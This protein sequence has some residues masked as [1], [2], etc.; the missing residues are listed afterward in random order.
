MTTKTKIRASRHR[1]QH[2]TAIVR[3]PLEKLHE[4]PANPAPTKDEIDEMAAW[5]SRDQDEPI[6]V[7]GD[8]EGLP[9]GH[10]QVLAGHRR[11]AAA[12]KLKWQGLECR[13]R[14]DLADDQKALT[15]MAATNQQRNAENAHRQALML[16]AMLDAGLSIRDAGAVYGLKSEAGVRNKLQLLKL[17]A[18]WIERIV[19][20]EISETAARCLVPYA[21]VPQL[22]AALNKRFT[23]PYG[24]DWRHRSTVAAAVRAV[25]SGQTRPIEKGHK[26]YYYE[27]GE[28]ARMF[29]LD[30]SLRDKLKIVRLPLGKGGRHVERATNVKLYDQLQQPLIKKKLQARPS[31]GGKAKPGK[32]S[33]QQRTSQRQKQLAERYRRWKHRMLR[34]QIAAQLEVD[35]WRTTLAMLLVIHAAGQC[36]RGAYHSAPLDQFLLSAVRH[37]SCDAARR[38]KGNIPEPEPYVS[39]AELAR[40]LITSVDPDGDPVDELAHLVHLQVA[41]L[42]W[43]QCEEATGEEPLSRG[44]PDSLPPLE[45]DLCAEIAHLVGATIAE[46]WRRGAIHGSRERPLVRE[47]FEIH[48]RAE[49]QQLGPELLG[50]VCGQLAD[51]R[52]Q[53]VSAQIDLVM[54]FHGKR[55]LPLPKCLREPSK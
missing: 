11:L 33:D 55:P 3:L 27:Q 28:H 39:D 13:I 31:R 5:L 21:D 7:R 45:D 49:L 25:I 29:R 23:N 35:D 46:G 36:P 41:F 30:D 12:R 54:G 47:F 44:L 26:H 9:I 48:T 15:F 18:K 6:T 52:G 34:M 37:N 8:V 24:G 1:P 50:P 32:Q 43:P 40:I 22:M 16:R 19:S 4:H 20:G 53:K 10:Y 51:S 38:R 17:P 2:D 14:S 42:I